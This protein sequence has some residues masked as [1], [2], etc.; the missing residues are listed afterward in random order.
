MSPIGHISISYLA[1]KTSKRIYMPAILLGAVFPDIDFLLLPF[2]GFN[3]VHRLFTHNLFIILLAAG[4]YA[5]IIK[6]KRVNVFFSF[7]AGGLLHLLVDACMDG[8]PSNGIGIA[9]FWPFSNQYFSPF[10]LST[11]VYGMAG[12]SEPMEMIKIS[13]SSLKWEMPF[14]I[15]TGI[16]LLRKHVL[17]N[18]KRVQQISKEGNHE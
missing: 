3:S 6:R 17:L 7:F 18:P 10:N 8:N 13:V 16:I 15:I 12:W 14:Y 9:L 2:S 4:I 5:L 1:G 11:P